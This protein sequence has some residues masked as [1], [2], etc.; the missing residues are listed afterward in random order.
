[1]KAIRYWL[2]IVI[3]IGF[4]HTQLSAGPCDCN[5][6]EFSD[7]LDERDFEAVTEYINTKRTID[8]EEKVT[9]L[10]ISG[11]IRTEWSYITEKVNG[12]HRRGGN[13]RTCST[14]NSGTP[15][16]HNDFDIDL[17]LYF[18]YK[19]ERAWGVAHIEFDNPA[20]VQENSKTCGFINFIGVD[21]LPVYNVCDSRDPYAGHGSG[22][23][24]S[25]CLRKAYIGYNICADGDSRLDIELGRRRLYDVFDSRIQFLAR[26]DGIVARYATQWA[27]TDFYWNIGGFVVDERV[28]HYAWVTELGAKNIADSGL[29]LKYSFIDW[30]KKGPNRCGVRNSPGWQYQN[31]QWLVA[32]HFDPDFIC[33]SAKFYGAFLWNHA[34][35]RHNYT[36][37]TLANLGYYIGFLFGEVAA[38]GDFSLDINYQYVEAQ[39]IPDPDNSGIGRGNVLGESFTQ[40][41]PFGL[42]INARGNGNYKGFRIEGLYAVTD[43]LSLD[44]QFQYSK[45]VNA[46]IG[47]TFNYS[48]FKIEAIYAF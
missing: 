1:M 16:S 29:D 44:A 37:N 10:A 6:D 27:C 38:E 31:S 3:A 22:R 40:A 8:L 28:N 20:G 48:K 24:D 47:G 32:Y 23:C 36:D 41:L 21:P 17:N 26:F 46:N 35:K 19:C 14:G 43:N 4:A 7:E 45:P 11:D 2:P 25:L 34:A 9:N 39:A 12:V 15:I 18:D 33:S 5:F 13:A 42:P 30:Q